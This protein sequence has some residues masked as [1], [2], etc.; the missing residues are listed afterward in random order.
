MSTLLVTGGNGFL[1]RQVVS[2][3]Q[4]RGD[5]VRV[6]ALPSEETS[7]LRQRG[8]AVYSGDVRDFDTLVAPVHGVNAVLHLAGLMGVWQPMA[9]Y[10]AVNVVG[11]A[12]VCRAALAEEARLVHVSSWTV[13]GMGLGKPVHEAFPLKPL[14]EP[15]SMTKAAGDMVVQRMIVDDRLP[16]VI[17]RPGTIF[18]PGDHLNFARTA[19]RLRGRRNVLVGSGDNALPLVYAADVVQGLLRALDDERAIG[20]AYNI[21]NDEPLTQREFLSTIAREIGAAPPRLRVSYG[22]FYAG[23]CV[24]EH[25]ATLTRSREPIVTRH[26]VALFG[27]D[28]RHSIDKARRELGYVPQ[29]GLLEG[30]RIS[31]AWY[32]TQHQS[33]RSVNAPGYAAE[34][35]AG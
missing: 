6:L 9:D 20:Q 10:H 14:G 32:R 25:L 27:T 30:L 17:V 33:S 16:A 11:T 19:D 7:W 2:A 26:G 4:D 12:N 1:G 24:A 34:E 22:A 5:T 28:N 8:V 21:T 3:L 13:Y 15:Y 18:G 29:I 23:A 35:V 31:A